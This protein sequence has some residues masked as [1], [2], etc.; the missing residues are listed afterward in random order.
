MSGKKIDLMM[1][2]QRRNGNG[3]D[4]RGEYIWKKY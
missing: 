2:I 4:A 1:N 3:S